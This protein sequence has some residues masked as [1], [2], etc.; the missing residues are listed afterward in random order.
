MDAVKTRRR[1]SRERSERYAPDTE[2]AGLRGSAPA[3]TEL[4]SNHVGF[5][6]DNLTGVIEQIRA[7]KLRA[8]AVTSSERSAALPEVPTAAEA[9]LPGF[10]STAWFGLQVPA[11]TPEAAVERL[12]AAVRDAV[13]VPAAR[14]R[15]AQAGAD[16]AAS[17]PA[18][19]A[20]LMRREAERWA[21]VVKEAG[22]SPAG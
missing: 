15:M 12:N 16:A 10:E 4:L 19:L 5:L 13:A 20:A 17:S 9:G 22:I 7:G 21:K 6:V 11:G 3:Q 8:L 2:G 18:E 14:E 1:S